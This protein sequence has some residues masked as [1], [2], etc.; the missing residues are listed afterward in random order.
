MMDKKEDL[1]YFPTQKLC[2]LNSKLSD[3]YFPD[4]LENVFCQKVVTYE[5]I[6]GGVKIMT[7]TRNFVDKSH[8][9]ARET[10]IMMGVPNE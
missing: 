4:N 3:D 1:C 9:D 7:H 8:Y 2:S 5:R 10:Q 6:K